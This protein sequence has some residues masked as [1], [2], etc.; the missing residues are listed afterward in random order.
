MNTNANPESTHEYKTT[1]GPSPLLCILLHQP[2]PPPPS[3]SSNSP[4]PL[5]LMPSP[6]IRQVIISYIC[7]AFPTGKMSAQT[8]CTGQLNYQEKFSAERWKKGVKV[9][10][11][12]PFSITV[13]CFTFNTS[14][15]FTFLQVE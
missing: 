10:K 1:F 6:H 7:T 14:L 4:P 13:H 2:P 8:V 3:S 11:Q 15:H 12:F 9:C 5:P